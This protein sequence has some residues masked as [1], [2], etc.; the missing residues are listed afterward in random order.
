MMQ[1]RL[2]AGLMFFVLFP[3]SLAR[4][5][6]IEKTADADAKRARA[7]RVPSDS[8][9]V[10]GRLDD[11]VWR[12]APA[13]ADFTQKEPV[14]GA[15]ATQRMEV[16]F[17]YDDDAVYVGARM[18]SADPANIQAPLGRRDNL[19]SQ[20]EYFFVSLDTYHDR[21]TA[22]TFGVSASGVRID[23]YYSRDDEDSADPGFDAVWEAKTS[24][25]QQVGPPSC[26]SRLRS[27][28]STRRA[29]W[30]GD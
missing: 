26:G 8:I 12:S 27:F 15:P 30:S 14:E 18:F 11:E 6:S 22:Y 23:R 16:R 9:R 29:I 5:Q 4:G 13:I 10:D 24:V 17:A 28:G 3:I 2:V 21:R 1:V 20:A 25:D 7:V 19:G